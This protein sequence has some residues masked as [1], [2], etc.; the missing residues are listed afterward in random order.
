MPGQGFL[1]SFDA[2]SGQP[3]PTLL[4]PITNT[5]VSR[6]LVQVQDPSTGNPVSNLGIPTSPIVVTKNNVQSI[7]VGTEGGKLTKTG[8]NVPP[9]PWKM[10]G[11]ERV[12]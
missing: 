1:Y 4:D 12:R 7:I 2:F 6:I 5:Y 3:T 11:W 10:Q 9:V 8:T